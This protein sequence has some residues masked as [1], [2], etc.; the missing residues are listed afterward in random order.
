MQ[1]K[2]TIVQRLTLNL[3]DGREA[4]NS[5]LVAG[6]DRVTQMRA[7]LALARQKLLE[8][9][10]QHPPGGFAWL[11]DGLAQGSEELVNMFARNAHRPAGV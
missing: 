2:F 6:P 7:E 11:R 8:T 4:L 1:L 5:L 9:Q 10:Q 3:E